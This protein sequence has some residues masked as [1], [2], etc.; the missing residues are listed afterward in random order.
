MSN[1]SARLA[2]F[3]SASNCCDGVIITSEGAITKKF[4]G[5]AAATLRLKHRGGSSEKSRPE[6]AIMRVQ[7]PIDR[8]SKRMALTRH[9]GRPRARLE[10]G[11]SRLPIAIATGTFDSHVPATATRGPSQC[12]KVPSPRVRLLSRRGRP[13]RSW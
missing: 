5:F 11:E 13:R 9:M 10:H 8:T 12:A 2:T 6:A 3:S 4:A 1:N 7:R